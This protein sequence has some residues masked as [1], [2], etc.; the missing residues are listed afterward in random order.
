MGVFMQKCT[1]Q[2]IFGDYEYVCRE[3]EEPRKKWD[4][5]KR[6]IGLAIYCVQ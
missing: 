5:K 3:V 2:K 1:W 4:L 6:A